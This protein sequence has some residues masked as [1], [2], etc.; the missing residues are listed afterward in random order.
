MKV[1]MIFL[2]G[3]GLGNEDEL[4]PYFYART[5]FF[6][7]ILEGH[8]LYNHI[9]KIITDR[10]VMIPTDALLGVIGTPQSATGQTTL[11]TGINAAKQVGYH[12]R[13]YPT[14]PLR[15]IISSASI[16]KLFVS[17]GQTATF[18]NA[19]NDRYFELVKKRKLR[20]SVSTLITLSAGNPLRNLDDLRK[21]RAVYQEFTNQLLV[22][23]GYAVDIISPEEAGENLASIGKEHDFTLY[24]YFITDKIGHR[25]DFDAAI[26]IYE[27]LDAFI[28]ACVNASDLNKT[29]IMLVSDHGNIE[30]LSTGRHTLNPV[31][32]LIINDHVNKTDYEK[33]HS[34]TDITP[35]VLGLSS[36]KEKGAL[37]N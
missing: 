10:V 32:T 30:D 31:P 21:G 19:Y 17:R 13:A 28:G 3:F 24:E 7:S 18:A 8:L 14:A 12:V 36:R 25:R 1:I 6:D 29:L 20:H 26:K 4:N 34:L 22:D 5:P 15:E 33:I 11:W 35:Y 16:M 27:A 2:D 23:R 9:G 37:A